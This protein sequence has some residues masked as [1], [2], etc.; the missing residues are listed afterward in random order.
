MLGGLT[1]PV[2]C[3]YFSGSPSISVYPQLQLEHGLGMLSSI[4]ADGSGGPDR[5]GGLLENGAEWM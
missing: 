5:G 2:F 1:S 3:A 4:S